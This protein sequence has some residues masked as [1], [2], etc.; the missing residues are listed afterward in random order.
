MVF[1]KMLPVVLCQ[2]RTLIWVFSH[3]DVNASYR[4]LVAWISNCD[5]NKVS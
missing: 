5:I 2:I 4:L 3:A 1:F